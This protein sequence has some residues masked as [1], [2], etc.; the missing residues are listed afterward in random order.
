MGP[1]TPLC[2]SRRN[3][4]N[5][6]RATTTLARSQASQFRIHPPPFLGHDLGEGH[7]ADGSERPGNH[8]PE[9]Q[10]DGCFCGRRVHGGEFA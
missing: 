6:S 7:G 5:L 8:G 3:V 9:G 1:Y 10:H 4:G 2:G